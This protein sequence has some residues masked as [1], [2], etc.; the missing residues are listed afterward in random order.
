MEIGFFNTM[1]AD[2]DF[3]VKTEW[4]CDDLQDKRVQFELTAP[5]KKVSGIGV[6]RISQ[7]PSG[8]QRIEIVVTTAPSY[9]ERTDN[10]FRLRQ[11]HANRIQRHPD[12]SVAE[13][14]LLA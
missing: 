6:F 12:Q 8:Q 3:W 1:S 11:I 2:N 10:I 7:R 14:Q 5:D 13:F 4:S 9:W